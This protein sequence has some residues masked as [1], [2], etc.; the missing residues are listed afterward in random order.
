MTTR[1]TQLAHVEGIL[2]RE[3]GAARQLLG[4]GQI[5]RPVAPP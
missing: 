2:D 1:E 3:R 5:G 4:E